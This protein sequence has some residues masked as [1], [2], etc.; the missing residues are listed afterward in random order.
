[1]FKTTT[2]KGHKAFH[3]TLEQADEWISQC[4]ANNSWGFPDRWLHETDGTHT[5]TREIVG[6]IESHTEYFFPAE[7]TIVGPTDLTNDP[8][9]LLQKCLEE[10]RK[11]YPSINECVEALME[12]EAGDKTK[13]DELKIKRENVKIKY[14]KPLSEN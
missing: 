6:E 2:S 9:Y 1:M 4:V 5:K 8:E 12:S 10:R 13:L 14:P 3:E 7:Y 11:E